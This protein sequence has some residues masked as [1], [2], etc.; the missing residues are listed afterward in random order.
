M[1]CS[2]VFVLYWI[3]P[4]LQLPSVS[5][6]HLRRMSLRRYRGVEMISFLMLEM[7]SLLMSCIFPRQSLAALHASLK[8]A[9]V[10]TLICFGRL[11]EA[12]ERAGK[13]G[14]GRGWW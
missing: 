3:F 14:R 13:F 11:M 7:M 8:D 10:V 2:V 9:L 12:R 6:F 1:M 4:L 5:T